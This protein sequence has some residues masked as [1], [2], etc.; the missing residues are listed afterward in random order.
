MDHGHTEI[1]ADKS[2]RVSSAAAFLAVFILLFLLVC[3]FNFVKAS[4]HAEE[5]HGAEA[6]EGV[7]KPEGD[8][9]ADGENGKLAN[10]NDA[11]APLSMLEYNS[12]HINAEIM[13]A[14]MPTEEGKPAAT[15]DSASIP[16]SAPAANDT[17]AKTMP[18][19][20]KPAAVKK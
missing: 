11:N 8:F 19:V 16:A 17:A 3:T 2:P 7:H 12:A 20:A 1:V 14:N 13:A 5:G 6:V 4:G 9:N 18:A 10:H 15:V